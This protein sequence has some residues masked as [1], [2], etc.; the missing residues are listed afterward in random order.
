MLNQIVL[1]GRI[2]RIEDTIVYIKNEESIIPI[3]VS[4]T[5]L[6]NLKEYCKENDLI[7]IK[8]KIKIIDN[9]IQIFAERISF[10]SSKKGKE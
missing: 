2:Q 9:N 4:G 10:L 6:D 7:A 8:G 5:I 1:I 3:M